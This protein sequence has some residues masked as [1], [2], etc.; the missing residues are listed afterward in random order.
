MSE[1]SP[2]KYSDKEEPVE[3]EYC[4]ACGTP[5]TDS[6]GFTVAAM[7]ISIEGDHPETRRVENHFGKTRFQICYVCFLKSLGVKETETQ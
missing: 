7:F 4:A 6:A 2:V 5:L 3:I 1:I